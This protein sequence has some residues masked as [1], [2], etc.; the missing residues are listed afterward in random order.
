MLAAAIIILSPA[1]LA[2][3][4]QP[5]ASFYEKFAAKRNEIQSL[6]ARFTQITSTPDEIITSTGDIYYT[7]P[8]R[9][10][11]RYEDAELHYLID[12]L[13]AY[14]YDAELQ[15]LQIFD[16]EDRPEAEAFFLGFEKNA[17]RLS[18]AY[19]IRVTEISETG[20]ELEL[21]PR[22]T[23]SETT[24]FQSLTLRL[25]AGDYLPTKIHI[26]NDDES[27]VIYDIG[28]FTV[29]DPRHKTENLIFLPE[30]T[31]IID[32]DRYAETVGP[33]GKSVPP[34]ENDTTAET[35]ASG[36]DESEETDT[37]TP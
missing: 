5:V 12:G 8:K 21:K 17:D 9:I 27:D 7:S 33:G 18:E 37:N 36:I 31:V 28:D 26:V 24:F 23:E 25:R 15:Q 32:N 6:H 1:F 2:Q 11:F 4:D 29:N 13:R 35:P 3:T 34:F 20:V 10:L 19:H 30:G 22:D 16:M 14:E